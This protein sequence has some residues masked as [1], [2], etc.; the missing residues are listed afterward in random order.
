MPLPKPVLLRLWLPC[1]LPCAGRQADPALRHLNGGRGWCGAQGHALWQGGAILD[2]MRDQLNRAL[3]LYGLGKDRKAD[4]LCEGWLN[5]MPKAPPL[6]NGFADTAAAPMLK[7]RL[8]IDHIT[9]ADRKTL[10]VLQD[11][12]DRDL[13]ERWMSFAERSDHYP[14]TGGEPMIAGRSRLRCH[15]ARRAETVGSRGHTQVG[16]V[17]AR[18]LE[19]EPGV[20]GSGGCR[21]LLCHRHHAG[22]AAA[23]R[24]AVTLLA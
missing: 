17:P 7:A 3:W 1:P 5:H 11:W 21:C 19:A 15:P 12:L 24:C 2:T 14:V 20:S 18:R 6:F 23:I 8:L 22:N 16:H 13:I 10:P 9:R 4:A